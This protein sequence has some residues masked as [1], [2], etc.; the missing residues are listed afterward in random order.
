MGF[1]SWKCA[2]TGKSIANTMALMPEWRSRCALVLPDRKIYELAYDGYGIFGDE[3]IF[4]LLGDG[5]RSKGIDR[6]YSDNPNDKPFDVKVVLA[7]FYE[8]E[9]YDDLSPSPIA[10][11]QGYFYDKD[12][13]KLT[14]Q[15]ITIP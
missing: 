7:D 3:D 2:K 9:S 6:Y 10:G 4:E 1:F 15:D 11:D 5:D 12:D 8:G 13:Y 14:I